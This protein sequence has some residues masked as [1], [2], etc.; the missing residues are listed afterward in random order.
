SLGIGQDLPR[1][2]HRVR[3]RQAHPEFAETGHL[4]SAVRSVGWSRGTSPTRHGCPR[5][6]VERFRDYAARRDVRVSRPVAAR[7]VAAAGGALP[8]PAAAVAREVPAADLTLLDDLED[9]IGAAEARIAALLPATEYQILTST[10]GW[11]V[12]RAAGYAAALGPP[13]RWGSAAKIY[14][15][16]GLSPIVYASAGKRRDGGIT[17]RGLGTPAPRPDRAGHLP[18][19]ARSRLPRLR[20]DPARARQARRHHLLRAPTR[21]PTRWSATTPDS[22]RPAGADPR[23]SQPG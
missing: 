6:G 4:A 14:R 10:P 12:I 17:P 15:A 23:P 22:T 1:H 19:A 8:T 20:P 9:Q 16:S 18:V 2:F 3:L 21:S 7:L 11:G 5:L 13:T